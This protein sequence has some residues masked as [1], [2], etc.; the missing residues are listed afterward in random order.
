MTIRYDEY[1]N[2]YDDGEFDYSAEDNAQPQ[3]ESAPVVVVQNDVN[4]DDGYIPVQDSPVVS[5]NLGGSITDDFSGTS[6]IPMSFDL[7]DQSLVT[8]TSDYYSNEPI[9]LSGY[10]YGFG[11]DYSAEPVAPSSGQTTASTSNFENAR[12]TPLR[13][14]QDGSVRTPMRDFLFGRKGRFS[15]QPSVYTEPTPSVTLVSDRSPTSIDSVSPLTGQDIGSY[16]YLSGL[17]EP[18]KDLASYNLKPALQEA[19]SSLGE[20]NY[21]SDLQTPS[22][23]PIFVDTQPSTE[24]PVSIAAPIS[25]YATFAVGSPKT[26]EDKKDKANKNAMMISGAGGASPSSELVADTQTA[27]PSVI[28]SVTPASQ[29][30][31]ASTAPAPVNPLAPAESVEQRIRREMQAQFAKDNQYQK[32]LDLIKQSRF[33]TPL[34]AKS[35]P[36][37]DI[38][39]ANSRIMSYEAEKNAKKQSDIDSQIAV[40]QEQKILDAI[41]A[42]KDPSKKPTPLEQRAG[43]GD[44]ST[45]N[46]LERITN[47]KPGSAQY[48]A[49][50]DSMLESRLQPLTEADMARLKNG[51]SVTRKVKLLPESGDAL[52][53]EIGAAIL[54][55]EQ[56]QVIG[57]FNIQVNR[58]VREALAR[59]PGGSYVTTPADAG[60]D[61]NSKPQTSS[62]IISM[63]SGGYR[64]PFVNPSGQLAF[65]EIKPYSEIRTSLDAENSVRAINEKM[66]DDINKIPTPNFQPFIAG[67]SERSD[68][69]NSGALDSLKDKVESWSNSVKRENSL[70]RSSGKSASESADKSLSSEKSSTSGSNQSFGSQNSSNMR[71]GNDSSVGYSDKNSGSSSRFGSS[72]DQGSSQGFN[73]NFGN[74]NSNT[75]SQG[76]RES[77]GKSSSSNASQ[78]EGSSNSVANT[79]GGSSETRDNRMAVLKALGDTDRE[80]VHNM[81]LDY[82]QK[83][84]AVK[85]SYK[86]IIKPYLDRADLM[87]KNIKAEND[88]NDLIPIGT[89]DAAPFKLATKALDPSMSNSLSDYVNHIEN[90]QPNVKYAWQKSVPYLNSRK[91][92]ANNP[93]DGLTPLAQIKFPIIQSI[94]SGNLGV[95]PADN[96]HGINAA[97][98]LNSIQSLESAKDLAYNVLKDDGHNEGIAKLINNKAAHQSKA[99][100]QYN[101]AKVLN[102]ADM[103]YNMMFMPQKNLPD[104]KPEP[105]A[106]MKPEAF[107]ENIATLIHNDPSKSYLGPIA[108]ELIKKNQHPDYL[109]HVA[110]LS[111]NRGYGAIWRDAAKTRQYELLNALADPKNFEAWY[112]NKGHGRLPY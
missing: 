82:E 33:A 110:D 103:V 26:S 98:F 62:P 6:S 38:D 93:V 111:T 8:D 49:I 75:V 10:D 112:S 27:A 104:G 65:K 61:L 60:V 28:P 30:A 108:F 70:S 63:P 99:V 42:A 78:T 59:R 71:S 66:M 16:D 97:K 20:Y 17:Q 109:K 88:N 18:S 50:Q 83:V 15:E 35:I 106:L 5:S 67:L 64:I 73:Q 48:Q 76:S 94:L 80:Q 37:S 91:D 72:F 68:F 100:Q 7:P 2:P 31:Q 96:Q 57:P 47:S 51:Q 84:A 86:D 23:D 79:K 4:S 44:L 19:P 45:E 9:D 32:D 69:L 87:A 55:G 92:A 54:P 46:L 39:L 40:E 21:I 22:I 85:N 56:G 95:D 101:A 24:T 3:H 58:H 107:I 13:G 90:M 81:M 29:V 43:Q 53:L 74:S 14:G 52:R 36:Q 1:G 89:K 77:S 105:R 102:G 25:K 12:R 34:G 11:N 41:A